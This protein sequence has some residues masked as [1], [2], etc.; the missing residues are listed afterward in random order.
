MKDL[1]RLDG[2]QSFQRWLQHVVGKYADL[3]NLDIT[4]GGIVYVASEEKLVV[5]RSK[6][7]TIIQVFDFS[8]EKGLC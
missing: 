8:V 7:W 5:K 1:T 6:T 4:D 3:A 2:E